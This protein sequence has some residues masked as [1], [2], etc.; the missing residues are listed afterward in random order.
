MVLALPTI[1]IEKGDATTYLKNGDVLNTRIDEGLF[2]G[3][4][5]EVAPTLAKIRNAL[6]SL[7][8]VFSNINTFLM[9]GQKIICSK[10]L[11]ILH[12]ASNSLINC[13][14]LQ[15]SALAAHLIM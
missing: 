15:N 3:L 4:T 11:P 14:I 1:I 12:M 7:N 13:W 2:G 6:D 9:R 5:A 10:P 8:R